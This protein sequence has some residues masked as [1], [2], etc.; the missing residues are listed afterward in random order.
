M[1][2]SKQR[3]CQA[4]KLAVLTGTVQNKKGEGFNLLKYIRG[5]KKKKKEKKRRNSSKKIM[6]FVCECSVCLY[7]GYL[8][9]IK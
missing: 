2:E 9:Q 4:K 1:S 6:F 3:I 8:V 7:V 5:K